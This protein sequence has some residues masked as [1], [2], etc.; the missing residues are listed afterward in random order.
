[1]QPGSVNAGSVL[2]PSALAQLPPVVADAVRR[3]LADSLLDVFLAALPLAAVALLLTLGIKAMPL[4]DT[5][6]SAEDT[7]REMLD[8]L[9]S[10]SPTGF[11]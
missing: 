6:Q 9:G 1:M 5:I 10:A 8:A 3:G 11:T 4:R 7:G 2:D